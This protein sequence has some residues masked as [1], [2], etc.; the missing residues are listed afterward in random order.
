MKEDAESVWELAVNEPEIDLTEAIASM[1][2]SEREELK[3]NCKRVYEAIRT[4]E[5]REEYNF[6]TKQ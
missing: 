2:K 3:R 5:I 6:L 1:F 4:V